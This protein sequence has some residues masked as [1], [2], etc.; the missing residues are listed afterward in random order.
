[1]RLLSWRGSAARRCE[2]IPELAE[3]GDA[4]NVAASGRVLDAVE[5]ASRLTPGSGQSCTEALSGQPTP[6]RP[7]RRGG[8]RFRAWK[9]PD[10]YHIFVQ[11]WAVGGLFHPQGAAAIC[12]KGA[13]ADGVS[14]FHPRQP[15]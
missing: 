14:S 11:P 7:Y 8:L 13:V 6:P 12:D 9:S 15:V 4:D 2:F 3:A 10:R 5:D 1:M